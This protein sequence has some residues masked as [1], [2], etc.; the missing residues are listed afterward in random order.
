ME[1]INLYFNLKKYI[2]VHD[3][4]ILTSILL[5]VIIHPKCQVLIMYNSGGNEKVWKQI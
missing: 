5:H 3:I 1:C 2:S 4:G